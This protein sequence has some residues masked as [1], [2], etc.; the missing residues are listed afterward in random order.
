VNK[1]IK[2]GKIYSLGNTIGNPLNGFCVFLH[3][4]LSHARGKRIKMIILKL[5]KNS[6]EN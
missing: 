1:T 5:Q 6:R 4:I 3:A 2:R